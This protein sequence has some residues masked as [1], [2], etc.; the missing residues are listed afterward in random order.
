MKT[1]TICLMVFSVLLIANFSMAQQKGVKSNKN[2]GISNSSPSSSSGAEVAAGTGIQLSEIPLEGEPGN[3]YIGEKWPKG[4]LLLK[5]G[6]KIDN[7]RYRY[8]VYADQMQFISDNDTLA[9][10]AP[11]EMKMVTFDDMSFIYS[12]YECTGMLMKGYFEQLVDGKKQ[13]LLKR[14]V[15]YHL[16][17]VNDEAD[18]LKDTYLITTTCFLKDGIHPAQKLLINR[19]SALEAMSDHR[20][21]MEDFL[22]K[23]GNKVRTVDDLK[24]MVTYYNTLK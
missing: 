7:Y 9:F 3:L 2:A 24:K 18:G 20:K 14:T 5:D 8:D 19:K 22:Q 10:A 15:T 21:D 16:P 23:T 6:N 4:L 17:G 11:S 12:S 1:T 13:L